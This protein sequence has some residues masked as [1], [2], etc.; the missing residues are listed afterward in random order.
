MELGPHTAPVFPNDSWPICWV[1]MAV[2]CI[3]MEGSTEGDITAAC[4]T[5]QFSFSIMSHDK[6]VLPNQSSLCKNKNSKPQAKT[7]QQ[8]TNKKRQ[9]NN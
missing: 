1:I 2:G 5:R 4:G 9:H 7:K 8:Q 3:D 6:R